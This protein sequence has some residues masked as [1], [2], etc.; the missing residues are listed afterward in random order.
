MVIFEWNAQKNLAN[1][2]KHGISFEEAVQIF[3]GPIITYASSKKELGERRFISV[4]A[5]SGIVV[6]AVIHTDRSGSTRIISARKANRKE[7]Q[8]YY[9]YLKEKVGK[10]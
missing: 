3:K 6:I 7:R 1:L 2:K 8:K 9:E 10:D 4:G 5:I